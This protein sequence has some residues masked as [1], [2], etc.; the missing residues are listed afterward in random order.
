MFYFNIRDPIESADGKTADKTEEVAARAPED[1]FRLSG[2]YISEPGVLEAI[3]EKV[4][5][6]SRPA[7]NMMMTR[8][9]Y[10]EARRDVLAQI[11]KTASDILSG[12][13]SVR[14]FKDKRG[15]ACSRC[16]YKSICRRDR[17]YVKNSARESP[18]EP[19][20]SK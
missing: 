19:K 7:G 10:E 2:R 16:G 11:E 18:P 17:E 12:K 3:P 4:L 9:Q 8:E 15:L 13:I 20:G 6:P 1:V 5:K 14:P